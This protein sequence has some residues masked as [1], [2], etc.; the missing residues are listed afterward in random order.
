DQRRR[1]GRHGGQRGAR[2]RDGHE[3]NDFEIKHRRHEGLRALADAGRT[4]AES[5]S[6]P[7]ARP[8]D[9]SPDRA[10][11]NARKVGLISIFSASNGVALSQ[12]PSSATDGG[13]ETAAPKRR[14]SSL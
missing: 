7:A 14:E 2:R 4:L 6:R 1:A 9:V 3:A 10:S 13:W 5:E 12:A 8:D 11:G